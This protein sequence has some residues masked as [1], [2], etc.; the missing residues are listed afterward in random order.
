MD[1][2]TPNTKSPDLQQPLTTLEIGALCLRA[3]GPHSAIQAIHPLSG[4]EVNTVYIVR[5]TDHS[6]VVLR[7]APRV[8]EDLPRQH[9]NAM[10]R[11]HS[12]QP[13]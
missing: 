5:L 9:R 3:F 11:E 7:V 8:T 6:E 4:G 2:S 1:E 13:L 10:R 12:I